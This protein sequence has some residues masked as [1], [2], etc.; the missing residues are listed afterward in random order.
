[1]ESAAIRPKKNALISQSVFGI[2]IIRF[3]MLI[4]HCVGRVT[5]I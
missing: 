5:N 4:E 3:L 2:N 1:M